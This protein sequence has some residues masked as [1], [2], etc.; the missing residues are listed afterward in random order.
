M[1]KMLLLLSQEGKANRDDIEVPYYP[2]QNGK[3]L[4]KESVLVKTKN[5]LFPFNVS[6]GYLHSQPLW[7]LVQWV[8]RI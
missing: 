8:H 1:V 3:H 4:E 2:C 6:V 7:I 5:P